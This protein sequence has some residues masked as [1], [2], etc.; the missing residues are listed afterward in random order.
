MYLLYLDDSGSVGNANETHLVLGGV[1]VH[2]ERLY[3]LKKKLDELAV[4]LFGDAGENEEFHCSE[5]FS[6]RTPPWEK[7][8]SKDQRKGIILQILDVAAKQCS[9]QAA[10]EQVTTLIACAINKGDY[11]GRDAMEM[12]FEEIC[13]RF[14]L[15]LVRKYHDLKKR[16][17]GMIILDE[18]TYETPLQR[19]IKN[20]NRQGDRWGRRPEDIVEVPL[21]VDSRA[22]RPIQLA[23]AV[24]YAV[25]RYYSQ[26]DMTYF[27]PIQNC[28]DTEDGQIRGLIH[29][30]IN[31]GCTCPSCLTRSLSKKS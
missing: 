11:P 3:W 21:F 28:F 14:Q 13:N 1:I 5:I 7:F 6:G 4:R 29:K 23:D 22:S 31:Q 12:A 27:N 19:L 8:T 16:V 18:S 17:K 15:F 2:E 25:F 30:S 20:F 26:M 24:A 10:P 9:T